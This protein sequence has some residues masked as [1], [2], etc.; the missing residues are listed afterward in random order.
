[1]FRTS[2]LFSSLLMMLLLAVA[3]IAPAR[4]AET[5][6]LA[7]TPANPG[8]GVETYIVVWLSGGTASVS[9]RTLLYY[10][11]ITANYYNEISGFWSAISGTKNNA[12]DPNGVDAKMGATQNSVIAVTKSNID[13]SALPDG[14]YTLNF[15]VARKNNMVSTTTYAFTKNGT[16][17]SLSAPVSQNGWTLTTIT[18][19]GRAAVP[20]ITTQPSNA[21]VN[22]GSTATFT[23]AA[24]G[25]TSYQWQSSTNGT[26]WA[27]V[28]GGTGATTASYTTAATVVGDSG[29]L[30][31]CAATNATG[32][33]NSNSA[34]LAVNAIAP[35]ISAQPAA[36]SV[37][38]G[39]TATFSVTASSSIT[40]T[41]QWQSST[42]G[43]TWS[44]VS[45]GT[46]STSASYTT[47][48]TVI[49][50]S[51][52]SFRCAVTNATGTTNSNG[53]TLT[54][55]ALAPSITA[56][57]AAQS[58][59]VGSTATFSVTASSSVTM[60]YQWQVST[61][62]TS[63]ANVSGGTGAT[64][65]SYTTAATIAGDNGKSFRCVVTNS[66]SGNLS[67]TSNAAT[68]TVG[69]TVVAPAITTQPAN[70][71]V[72]DG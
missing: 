44:N 71:T 15:A 31:R 24:S 50:D 61:N 45:T 27:S 6:S 47:A 51:G 72:S 59:I 28:S 20:S 17:S 60:T 57:P 37:N 12:T 19:S 4:A 46:G 68:L 21:T 11:T 25:A 3:A 58:V 52:K 9:K 16:A 41:Y 10:G 43:T 32:T 7:F 8:G 42:N 5:L 65:T 64:T 39:S 38:V 56:Q 49:G 54:V 40:M 13:V 69:T 18:Y 53:A 34:T 66:G 22:E 33:T 67:T 29:K 62:G 55:N 35:V 63:W 23:I 26:T 70:T 1:M 48:A 2:S 36:K 14:S 30:F